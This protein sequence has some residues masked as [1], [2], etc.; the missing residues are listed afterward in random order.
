MPALY[1]KEHGAAMKKSS[2]LPDASMLILSVLIGVGSVVMFALLQ[3]VHYLP[4]GWPDSY[5]L[6]WDA[7]LSLAFFAQHSG[8]VRRP[9]RARLAEIIAPRYQGALYSI[10][11]GV[12]LALVVVLW[13]PSEARF[14]VLEGVPRW[15]AQGLSILAVAAFVSSA[16]TL[17]RSF[18]PLGLGPIRAHL[19][20]R[21]D[22]ADDFVVRGPYVWVRHPLYACILVL[23]W[24]NP[25]VTLDQFLLSVLWSTWIWVGATLEERDLVAEFGEVYR[26]YQRRV[27]MLIPWRGRVTLA[28][29]Q[30]GEPVWTSTPVTPDLSA[31]T[32]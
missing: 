12:V 25:D 27:P 29:T 19:R 14:F 22:R 11:S 8:M 4:M 9:V 1:S 13:Q 26:E 5:V 10:A 6:V 21:A 24:T 3:S 16:V 20:G 17:R 23:F 2:V 30:V 15:I 7:L 31:T 18:D 28:G 32:G